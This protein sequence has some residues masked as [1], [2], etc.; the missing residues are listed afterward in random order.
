[1]KKYEVTVAVRILEIYQ[2]EANDRASAAEAWSDGELIHTDDEAL[3][4]EV[5]RVKESRP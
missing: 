1:M 5:L 3:E 2:V 4:G